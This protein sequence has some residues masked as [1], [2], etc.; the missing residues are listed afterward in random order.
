MKTT[1]SFEVVKLLIESKALK[2]G[3]FTLKSGASSPFFIDLGQ[4]K[5]GKELTLL[6]EHIA[7]ALKEHYPSTTL[8]FGPAYKGIP[9]AS[10]TAIALWNLFQVDIP[11]L[12]D[13]KEAKDHGE[14]GNFIGRFPF[15]N[16][17]IVI[18][19]DVLTS[20]K[21]KIDAINSLKKAFGCEKIGNLVIV[22]RTTK[23]SKMDFE[24]KSLTSLKEIADYL[25]SIS[26][27][28]AKVIREFMEK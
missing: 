1:G 28:K 13:R 19:D 14:G 16:D 24:Y 6:G 17:R 10:A 9:L 7:K 26:D 3:E 4:V 8:L 20:G 5:S 18:I 2:F 15:P 21:T 23:S 27:Q 25:D 11:F 22:D 12:Y